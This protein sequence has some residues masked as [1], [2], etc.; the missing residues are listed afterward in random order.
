[1][2]VFRHIFTKLSTYVI[3]DSIN[4]KLIHFQNGFV[5]YLESARERVKMPPPA[6]YHCVAGNT[7][8]ASGP[9]LEGYN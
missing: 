9:W 7:E 1:M 8:T 6:T 5:F 3:F 2:L 4:Q